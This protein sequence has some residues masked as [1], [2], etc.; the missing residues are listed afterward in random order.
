MRRL[1]TAV[2][3]LALT[4]CGSGDGGGDGETLGEGRPL[5]RCS[6]ITIDEAA[7]WLGSPVTAAPSEGLDGQPS[8]VTCLYEGAN[9]TVLVQVRDGDIFHSE[10]GSPSRIGDDIPGLGED[11]Y[12][13]GSSV[14]FLQNDWSVAVGLIIGLL[15]EAALQEVAE[16]VSARLP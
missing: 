6:L 1:L 2:L 8:P 16:A 14:N 10:P 4:A 12:G 9:A 5:D 13:D 3:A 11:A 7:E 15:D